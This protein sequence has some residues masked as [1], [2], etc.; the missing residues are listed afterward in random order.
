MSDERIYP[1]KPEIAASAHFNTEGYRQL[2]E[3]SINEPE[4][5]WAEQAGAFL[6]WQQPW[7]EVLSYDYPKGEIAW[8][9]GGQLNVSA[10]CLDRHL[11]LR[12]D[13]IA[14]IWEGDDPDQQQ[15]LTYRELYHQ[16]CKFAN[17]LKAQ[18]VQKGDRV[19]IY[20]PMITEAA[21]VILACARI[22]GAGE[23]IAVS[24]GGFEGQHGFMAA[25]IIALNALFELAGNGGE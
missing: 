6:D 20:L 13:Q 24:L 15:Q 23:K 19:C 21:V 4:I 1:V 5:F 18:G 2:Y 22:G 16:V 17:V 14:I 3:Q 9:K 25:G 12:G 11:S 8:F 10:N 7:Q